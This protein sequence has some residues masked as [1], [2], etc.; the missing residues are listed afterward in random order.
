MQNFDAADSESLRQDIDRVLVPRD[1]IARRVEQ[2]ARQIAECYGHGDGQTGERELTILAVLTGSLV[3]LSDLI[4]R[5]PLK[6][7]IEV[8]SASSYPGRATVSKSVALA[9]PPEADFAGR[10]VLI[11]DDILDSGRTLAAIVRQVNSSRPASLRSCVL[12]SKQRRDVA[13]RIEA[14]FCG[15]EVEPEFVV[16]YGLD[17]DDLY[18]DLPDI[19]VLKPHVLAGRCEAGDTSGGPD[20]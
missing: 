17:F 14:D 10:D 2:L 13:E 6:I 8:M 16:G 9:M 7:R 19:C 18:R 20:E 1:E 15:F 5:L 4:R 12:L 11:V 3:F